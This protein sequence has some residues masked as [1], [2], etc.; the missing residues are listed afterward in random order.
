MRSGLERRIAEQLADASAPFYYERLTLRFTQP[1]KERKYTP[2]FIITTRTGKHIVLEVKGRWRLPD[3][4]KMVWVIEQHPHLDIRMLFQSADVPIRKGS[5]TS[6][7]DWCDK[8]DIR[9]CNG[10]VPQRWLDE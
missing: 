3:R 1:A 2:D 8:N 5:K 6:Y 4:Q 9:W 10:R 7:A